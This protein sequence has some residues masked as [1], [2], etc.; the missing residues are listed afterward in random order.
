MRADATRTQ[1]T[2]FGSDSGEKE[3]Q[4]SDAEHQLQQCGARELPDAVTP[5]DHQT[6]PSGNHDPEPPHGLL[7]KCAEQQRAPLLHRPETGVS[8]PTLTEYVF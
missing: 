1:S 6:D 7:K 3:A 8:L 2:C 4:E 5:T